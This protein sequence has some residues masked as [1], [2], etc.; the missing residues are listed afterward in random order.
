MCVK[1][2]SYTHLD[3]YKRLVVYSPNSED[4]KW[5]PLFTEALEKEAVVE[6]YLDILWSAEDV[7]K[8]QISFCGCYVGIYR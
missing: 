7:Y 3:V 1:T 4:E 2:V 5:H 6:Y 8:R